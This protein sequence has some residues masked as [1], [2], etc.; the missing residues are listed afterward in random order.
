MRVLQ[1]LPS[2]AAARGGPTQVVLHLARG[3]ADRGVDVEVLA[4]R[5]DLDDAAGADAV[6]A[7]SDKEAVELSRLAPS[8]R[9]VVAAPG[10]SAP[11][12]GAVPPDRAARGL[13]IGF[14]GR[15]HPSKQLDV[16]LRAF[17]R[18]DADLELLLGG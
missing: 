17:A 5:A 16:L 13:R 12:P 11:P 14:L 4:T 7:T 10:A 2:V 9:V 6:Q 18:L 15:I 3:L 8:A 1:V